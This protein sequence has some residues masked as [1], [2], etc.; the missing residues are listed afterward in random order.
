MRKGKMIAQAAHASMKVML[1]LMK[2]EK[3]TKGGIIYKKRT[4]TTALGDNIDTWLSGLFTKVCVYVNSEEELLSLHYKALDACIPVSLIKDAGLTEFN[5]V[6]TFTCI[7][8]G[9]YINEEIDKITG[10]LKLL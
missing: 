10:D 6:G 5:G 9:P 1:D 3:I 2:E 8:I 7:A 4:L